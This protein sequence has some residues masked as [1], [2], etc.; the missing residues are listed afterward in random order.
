[1]TDKIQIA[2]AA[3]HRYINGLLVTMVSI[4]R[5]ASDRRRLQFHVFSDGLLPEDKEM[6]RSFAAEYAVPPPV[7]VEPDM[8]VIKSRFDSTDNYPH[9]V[10][11]RLFY[12]DILRDLDW[13]VY[14]DVDT[15]WMRDICE[16]WNMR[17]QSAAIQW[18]NDLPSI[19]HG[20]SLYHHKWDP[21]F[22]ESRYGCSGVMLMNL[23]RLRNMQFT[24]KCVDFVHRWGTPFFVDQD[25]IAEICR[26]EI[27]ILPQYWDTMM[28]TREAVNGL[29]YHFNGIGR[30]FNSAFSGYKPLYYPWFRFFYDFVVKTPTHSVCSP[31]KRFFFW[32]LGTYYPSRRLIHLLTG[33]RLALTDNIQ[34]QLFFAWLWRHASWRWESRASEFTK[35]MET[36]SS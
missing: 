26:N 22:D 11:I 12:C 32:L 29:V 4:M 8:S 24:Q 5:S 30:L 2:L 35:W 25:I 36:T 34:R 1:M 20:V 6:V 16:L 13:V 7:F 17:D 21:D 10:F 14:T 27:K 18:S 3:N 33:G 19:A 31:P 23:K 9:T 28:P 15:L